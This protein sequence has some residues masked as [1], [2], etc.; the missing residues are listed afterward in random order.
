[1]YHETS[2]KSAQSILQSQ[3]MRLGSKGLAGGSIYLCDNHEKTWIEREPSKF[4]NR[5]CGS[6]QQRN[7]QWTLNNI[8][9]WV[10]FRLYERINKN[11]LKY[12]SRFKPVYVCRTISKHKLTAVKSTSTLFIED[13][14][15]FSFRWRHSKILELES[16]LR[17]S[18]DKLMGGGEG[19]RW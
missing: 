5:Q 1:M 8:R 11:W 12:P 2:P 13:F 16:Y 10:S 3:T 9:D 17:R 18:E 19:E 7:R 15:C 6:S 4:Q 14:S